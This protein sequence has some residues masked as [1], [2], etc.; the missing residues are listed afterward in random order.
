M[1]SFAGKTRSKQGGVCSFAGCRVLRALPTFG[2]ILN[3]GCLS[4][5]TNQTNLSKFLA[6]MHSDDIAKCPLAKRYVSHYIYL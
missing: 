4:C 5:K 1:C 2:H 3:T 6:G